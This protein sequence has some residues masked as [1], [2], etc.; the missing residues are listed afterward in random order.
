MT[1]PSEELANLREMF[2][3][4]SQGNCGD[5]AIII[6]AGIK[7]LLKMMAVTTDGQRYGRGSKVYYIDPVGYV[8]S[9]DVGLKFQTD[10][11]A[12]EQVYY[13]YPVFA[14]R[15]NAEKYRNER[16]AKQ[17]AGKEGLQP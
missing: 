9:L 6:A 10:S 15:A 5:D 7:L 12:P 8:Q 11:S 17:V 4:E 16:D 13:P 14:N 3:S 2:G 1:N